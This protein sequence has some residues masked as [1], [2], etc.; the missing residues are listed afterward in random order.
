MKFTRLVLLI[1]LLSVAS[2]AATLRVPQDFP[3]VQG[4]VAVSVAGDTIIVSPGLYTVP[5]SPCSLANGSQATCGLVL[6][7]GTALVGSGPAQTGLDFSG[8]QIGILVQNGTATVKL[9]HLRNAGTH[10]FAYTGSTITVDNNILTDPTGPNVGGVEL[11]QGNSYTIHNNTIDN[12]HQIGDPAAVAIDVPFG[13]NADIQNNLVTNNNRGV[14]A[15][16]LSFGIYAYNDVFGSMDFNWGECTS[17]GCAAVPAPVTNISSDPLYCPDFT[18]KPG[19]PAKNAGSPAILNPD[20]TRSDIG[21]YGGPEAI[22]PSTNC[23]PPP[24]HIILGFPVQGQTPYASPIS[25]VFDHS[26]KRPYDKDNKVIAFTADTGQ[27]QYGPG[28]LIAVAS[29]QQVILS[30]STTVGATQYTVLRQSKGFPLPQCTKGEIVYSGVGTTVTDTGLQNGAHY[31]YQLCI[32]DSYNTLH[33][34]LRLKATP[35][36]NA[37]VSIAGIDRCDTFKQLSGQPF[38]FG[39]AGNFVGA[40]TCGNSTFLSYDGHPGIDY[41]FGYATSLIAATNGIVTYTDTSAYL[42]PSDYHILTISST[43]DPAYTVLYL[44]LSSYYE[45]SSGQVMKRLS[46]GTVMTCPECPSEGS[47]VRKGDFVGYSGNYSARD[48]GWGGVAAHLHFEVRKNVGNA[49]IPVDPYGW[50][51]CTGCDRYPYASD[52]R[53]ELWK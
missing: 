38:S 36:P 45:A 15:G 49:F 48:G 22:L 26:M 29:N 42:T 24:S 37:P 17:A 47:T 16:S 2:F 13:G 23:E 35:K 43:D 51:G 32:T 33:S 7:D 46:D 20:G 6:H 18:L 31:F 4:A 19:S 34:G 8:A 30:W 44:H 21:A 10:I 41:R 40:G 14:T 52:T 25:A 50:Q 3:T 39:S 28:A 53:Q 1:L 11:N 9:F 5:A 12:I 27:R